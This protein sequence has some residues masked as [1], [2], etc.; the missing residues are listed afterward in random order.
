MPRARK[1]RKVC[2][3]PNNTYFYCKHSTD[4]TTILTI[5]EI[6]AIRLCDLEKY[7]QNVACEKMNVSR[8][9]F[10]RI[11]YKAHEKIAK[12]LITGENIK[13]S[14]GDYE[15]SNQCEKNC[16]CKKYLNNNENNEV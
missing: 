6:E 12:A 7:E 3:V 5:E 11:L 9:T 8:G 1:C 14:G 13:I 15:I 10:Q 2:F 16:C 4:K